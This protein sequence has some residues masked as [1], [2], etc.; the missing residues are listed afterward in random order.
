MRGVRHGAQLD[1]ETVKRCGR[2]R[3]GKIHGQL[4]AGRCLDGGEH[5]GWA[6]SEEIAHDEFGCNRNPNAREFVRGNRC[7]ELFTVDQHTVAIEDDH[8]NRAS[9]P[10]NIG[11]IRLSNESMRPH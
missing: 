3:I 4:A 7:S 6:A 10:P 5:I 1:T 8:G 11:Q 9:A 2:D